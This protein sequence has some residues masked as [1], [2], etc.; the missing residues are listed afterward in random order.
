MTTL[1]AQELRDA[2]SQLHPTDKV[3]V[4]VRPV[5]E[6]AHRV[7][8]SSE[9]LPTELGIDRIDPTPSTYGFHAIIRLNPESIL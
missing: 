3:V 8:P 9:E 7:S 6:L 5:Y 4:G 1:T 2:L